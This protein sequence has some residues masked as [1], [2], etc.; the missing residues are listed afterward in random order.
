[1]NNWVAA[2]CA[3]LDSAR[4]GEAPPLEFLPAEPGGNP[5]WVQRPEV[6]NPEVKD[7]R[8]KTPGIENQSP[9]ANNDPVVAVVRTSGSTGKPKQTLLTAAALE[10]SAHATAQ[11]LGGHGQWLL[12][13]QPSYV[14]GLAVLS[15]SLIAGTTPVALLEHTTDPVAFTAAANKLTAPRRYVS[16]VPTQLQRLLDAATGKDSAEETAGGRGRGSAELL[17]ALKRFDAILLGGGASSPSLL[18]AAAEAGLTTV[19]TYGMSET[20]GGC[21]Y[22]GAPLPGVTMETD[23]ENRVLLSGPMVAAGY[24][25]N[26]ELTAA[27]FDTH[28]ET[29][30][31][32]F[33]T[34]DLGVVTDGVLSLT[35]RADDVINTGGVKISAEQIRHVIAEHPQVAEAFVG[36]V[37]DRD[38]GQRVV[39][40]VM[41]RS[42]P[43]AVAPQPSRT[44]E[45]QPPEVV[46]L[47]TQIRAEINAAIRETLGAAAVP[48]QYL[49]VKALPKLAN[50]KPDRQQLKLMLESAHS[51][52]MEGKNTTWPH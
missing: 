4:H 32:R 30:Q 14:A 45:N 47:P 25:Q 37:G 7:P 16:L 33:R 1:M 43:G 8:A 46:E 27:A 26:P 19:R 41:P 39:A 10:A 31:P 34:D 13:L 38:W 20:C 24:F 49:Q 6:I 3:A 42:S 17:A 11:Q 9:T 28:P 21:V 29:D 52:Q 40:V 12:T 5:G 50:N 51:R 48:K 35:G 22:D 18:N 23:G 15:R 44:S 36:A 2:A